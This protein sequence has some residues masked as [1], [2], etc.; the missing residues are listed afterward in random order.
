MKNIISYKEF[1]A[2]VEFS[3][4]HNLLFGKI[5][6]IN[7]LVMFEGASVTELKAMFRE[8]VNEY[9][10]DCKQFK[11][12]LLKRFNGCFKVRLKSKI[13]QRAVRSARVKGLSLNK[14]VQKAIEKEIQ[15]AYE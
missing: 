13:Y 6:G 7:D 10:E 12:P 11:K 4:E 8:A 3:D 9:I 2:T 15:I 5:E 1:Y 14:L